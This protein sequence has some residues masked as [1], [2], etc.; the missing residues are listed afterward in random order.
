MIRSLHSGLGIPYESLIAERQPN[1]ALAEASQ[2][3]TRLSTFEFGNAARN[4]S[5]ATVAFSQDVSPALH[6]K[7]RTQ[8]AATKTDQS[9]LL[10]WQA[11]VLKKSALT[12]QTFREVAKL[13]RLSKGPLKAIGY[14][15]EKGICVVALPQ[16][17]G[18]YLDGAAMLD[19]RGN[20]VIGLTLRFDKTDSFWFTLLHELAHI[21][22][23]LEILKSD[24]AGFV[25]DIEMQTEDSREREA[26]EFARKALI[27]DEIL[28]QGFWGASCLSEHLHSISSRARV[29]VSIAAG[30][31]QREHGNYKKFSRLIERD[32][33]RPMLLEQL[34]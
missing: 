15:A 1:K 26:D 12:A 24:R 28:A 11:S 10:Q 31:W 21:H 17:P 19:H 14:L 16:L 25:D 23:H 7:T 32:V 6:R 8:R 5:S 2:S 27:P 3:R 18:T 13:S 22:L 9:A 33:L 30:R 4:L 20:P 29:H 34:D